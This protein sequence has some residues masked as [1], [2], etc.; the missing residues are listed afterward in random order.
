MMKT[1]TAKNPKAAG[2]FFHNDI[3]TGQVY[4]HHSMLLLTVRKAIGK[5]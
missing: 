3:E 1:A 5:I 2:F 4:Q